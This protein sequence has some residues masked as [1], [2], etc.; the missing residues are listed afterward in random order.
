MNTFEV[1]AITFVVGI[2]AGAVLEWKYG[3]KVASDVTKD[4]ATLKADVAE[5]KAKAAAVVAKV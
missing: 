3:A 5:L 4:I 1:S 2:V